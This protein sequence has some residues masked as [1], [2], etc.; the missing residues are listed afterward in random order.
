MLPPLRLRLLRRRPPRSRRRHSL[1]REGSRGSLRPRGQQQRRRRR[2]RRRSPM[3]AKAPLLAGSATWS[4]L[5]R[6]PLLLR[7]PQLRQELPTRSSRSRLDR[8]HRARLRRIINVVISFSRLHR[9]TPASSH[10]RSEGKFGASAIG[11]SRGSRPK[12]A[13]RPIPLLIGSTAL[14]ITTVSELDAWRAWRTSMI[15]AGCSS[16]Y[17]PLH[18]SPPFC[19][20]R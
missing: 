9:N 20:T 19:C 4:T 3:T 5:Q 8:R 15:R 10:T 17:V 2:R 13:G 11:V 18:P 16:R 7:L 1:R 12:S 6:P 14:P